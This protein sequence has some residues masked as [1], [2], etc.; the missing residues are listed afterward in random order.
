MPGHTL[1]TRLRSEYRQRY[2]VWEARQMRCSRPM[3]SSASVTA[4]A[5]WV[6]E[7][8]PAM[9]V[10]GHVPDRSLVVA[11]H[12]R[13]DLPCHI[14]PDRLELAVHLSD[15]TEQS[16]P[17][18][19]RTPDPRPEQSAPQRPADLIAEQQTLF[20]GRTPAEVLPQFG[21]SHPSDAWP[22]VGG[23]ACITMSG[24]ST[25]KAA[26]HRPA[27]LWHLLRCANRWRWLAGQAFHFG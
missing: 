5:Q 4:V 12:L 1:H 13:V 27:A 7:P 24:P 2:S 14:H 11:E 18:Q 20:P 16:R 6:M 9:L 19:R 22:W 10:V 8:E 26:G 21:Q 3:A 25:T 15:L 17:H 23:R